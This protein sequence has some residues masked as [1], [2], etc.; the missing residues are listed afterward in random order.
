M[1][2]YRYRARD[3]LGRV[4]DTVVEYDNKERLST[5]LE[6]MG[7]YVIDIN[8]VTDKR[9]RLREVVERFKGISSSD[10]IIFTRQLSTMINAGLSLLE[11]LSGL[12]KQTQN[13]KLKLA[14]EDIIERIRTG[15]AFPKALAA[16]PFI[17][18]EMYVNM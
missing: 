3:R 2:I 12:R 7:L 18:G 1:S 5:N 10:L 11:G 15:S 13:R 6:K 8:D 14:I 16:Y 17:F 4:V 9:S